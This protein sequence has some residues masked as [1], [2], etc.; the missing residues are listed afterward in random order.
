[1]IDKDSIVRTPRMEVVWEPRII[2]DK[3]GLFSLLFISDVDLAD[4]VL[5]FLLIGS[6]GFVYSFTLLFLFIGAFFLVG[7]MALILVM[8][9]ALL[10]LFGF[11]C[12]GVVIRGHP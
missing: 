2:M 11:T 3:C 9:L 7:G 12:L 8:M 1:M 4:G 6:F 10:F 5:L